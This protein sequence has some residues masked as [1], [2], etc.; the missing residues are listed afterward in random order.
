VQ[1]AACHRLAEHFGWCGTNLGTHFSA[2][3][4][5]EPDHFLLKPVDLWFDEVTASS[6]VKVDTKGNK[7]NDVPY[8]VNGAGVALHGGCY[9][10]R[11]D[12]NGVL[13]TH[14]DAGV[15]LS[16]LEC[17]LLPLSMAA[18]RFHKRIGYY[19]F[20]GPGDNMDDRQRLGDS[21]GSHNALIMR[22]HGLITVGRDIGEAFVVMCVLEQACVTQLKAMQTGAKLSMPSDVVLDPMATKRDGM[23]ERNNDVNWRMFLRMADRLDPSFRE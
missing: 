19:D 11:P 7:L 5:G 17:G 10:A 3:V 1:L 2:R 13:H 21:L 22:N 14:S 18:V 20:R 12:V 23:N 8:R 4:P 9:L 15:A 6:L 16:A